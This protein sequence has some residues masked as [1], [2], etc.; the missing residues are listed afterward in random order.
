MYHVVKKHGHSYQVILAAIF[1]ICAIFISA[2]AT[3]GHEANYSWQSFS[4]ISPVPNA[5]MVSTSTTIAVRSP[6]VTGAALFDAL[7]FTVNGTRS[8]R[9]VGEKVLAGDGRTVIFKPAIPF[10][11]G[12]EVT[13]SLD[14]GQESVSYS[15]HVAMSVPTDVSSAY[16]HQYENL[17]DREEYSPVNHGVDVIESFRTAP[18]DLPRYEVTKGIGTP[19]EG[20]VF[21]SPF[22]F[23][24]VGSTTAYLLI[25]DNNAEPVYYY[26][27][28][29]LPNA[30]DF[31]LNPNGQLTYHH[32][33]IAKFQALNNRYEEVA[34][35]GVGNGYRTDLH[36]IQ[37]LANGHRLHLIYDRQIMD[38]SVIVPGGHPEA[39]VTACIVQEIDTEENVVFEWR[40]W[41]HIPIIDTAVDVTRQIVNYMNC[42]SI[43]QDYD[44]NLLLSSRNLDEVTKIN[45]QTGE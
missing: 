8:G 9:H 45:R 27:F 43:E 5:E 16:A 11:A 29:N 10:E 28:P 2:G 18:K 41:D 35:Y 6:Q 7:S 33:A 17:Q 1:I 26:R 25:L 30:M 31:K 40:G 44:G 14:S 19:G 23:V 34:T 36:D 4:Y 20:Y 38:M 13:V 42:N 3:R 22:N 15:F 37:F 21:F 24:A 32:R 12:E 39:E